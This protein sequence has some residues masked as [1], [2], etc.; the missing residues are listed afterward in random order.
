MA[1]IRIR[2]LAGVL[3]IVVFGVL[4]SVDAA[5]AAA[6]VVSA[7]TMKLGDVVSGS[8]QYGRRTMGLPAG[9]WRVV[10]KRE[11]NSSTDGQ[12]ATMLEVAFDEVID[13]RLN[14]VLQ[15]LATKQSKSLNWIDEPCKTKGDSYW[16]EDRKRSMNDQFCIRVGFKSSIVDGARGEVFQA[17]ARDIVAKGVRY[18]PEMPYVSVV[19]YTSYDYLAMMVSFDP[20]IRGIAKSRR[21]ERQF[22]DWL[23]QTLG[24]HPDRARF[25]EALKA[26]APTFA[27]AVNRAFEGDEILSPNDFGGAV[28]PSEAIRRISPVEGIRY[29]RVPC[30]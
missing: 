19:R 5:S 17:W 27:S 4:L 13:S 12:G 20:S 28:V 23:P 10:S 30:A 25:Y 15:L 22:N 7:D 9:Q 18:S 6:P 26:W 24:E 8:L 14:R 3:H 16:L 2:M 21:V 11:R 1:P 29:T